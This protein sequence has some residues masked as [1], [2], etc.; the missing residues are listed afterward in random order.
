F[1]ESGAFTVLVDH[2]VKDEEGTGVVHQAPYFGADDHRVCMDFNIIQKDSTPV[3]PVDAS[4]CFTE[5]VT[6]VVGQYV[7]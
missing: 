1:K 6:H 7:K 4:G 2:Y 3:C 5:E